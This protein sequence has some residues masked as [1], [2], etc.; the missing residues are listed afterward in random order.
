MKQKD[1]EK[2]DAQITKKNEGKQTKGVEVRKHTKH[3]KDIS[4]N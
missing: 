3:R 4:N 1:T 2:G